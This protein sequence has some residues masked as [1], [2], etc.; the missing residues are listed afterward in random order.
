PQELFTISGARLGSSFGASI[1]SPAARIQDCCPPSA[2]NAL[3][4]IHF[5][6]GATPTLF[7][8]AGSCP[9]MVPNTWVPCGLPAKSYGIPCPSTASN[10]F[11]DGFGVEG[12]EG[13]YPRH[14]SISAS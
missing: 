8:P 3:A 13:S 14:L 4:A 2:A 10:Q 1:N 5:A 9:R 12:F 11:P 6:P 7:S